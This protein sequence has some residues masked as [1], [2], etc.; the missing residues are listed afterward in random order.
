[1]ATKDQIQREIKHTLRTKVEERDSSMMLLAFVFLLNRQV[2][3]E[4]LWVE[5]IVFI[6]IF[7][8]TH[9]KNTTKCCIFPNSTRASREGARHVTADSEQN[10]PCPTRHGRLRDPRGAGSQPPVLLLPFLRFFECLPSLIWSWDLG[11]N[12]P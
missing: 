5:G 11:K 6:D 2:L 3:N 7:P 8:Q 1:M 9:N 4:Y 12:F 10:A